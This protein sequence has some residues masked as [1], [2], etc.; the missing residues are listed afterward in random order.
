[1]KKMLLLLAVG[2]MTVAGCRSDDDSNYNHQNNGNGM[3]GA[4]QSQ[5]AN[6]QPGT[7]PNQNLDKN[8]PPNQSGNGN[9]PQQ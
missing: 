8:A 4:Y 1:M 6:P 5:P 2:G 9:P 3:N 7:Y